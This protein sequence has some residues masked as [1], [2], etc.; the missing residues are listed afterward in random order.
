MSY[1]KSYRFSGINSDVKEIQN[2][3]LIKLLD[4]VNKHSGVEY[5]QILVNWYQDGNDYI[6][7]HADDEKQLDDY[8]VC[9]FGPTRRFKIHS[10][11]EKY[12]NEFLL[13]NNSMFIMGNGFQKTMK[14]SVP[15]ELKVKDRR[16]N[17]TF[18]KFK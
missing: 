13:G 12:E 18:R 10:K 17:V 3:Y 8:P 1:G 14:H 9:S 5:N 16:I 15:K 4:W 6:G 11:D 2:P 7:C